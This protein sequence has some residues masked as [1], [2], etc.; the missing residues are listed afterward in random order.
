MKSSK[1]QKR[2]KSISDL[3]KNTD[4]QESNPIFGLTKNT[5]TV[6]FFDNKTD[7]EET[8]TT[9]LGKQYLDF[10]TVINKLNCKLEYVKSGSYGNVFRAINSDTNEMYCVK[11]VA[12]AKKTEYGDEQNLQ[13]PENSEICMLKLLSYF[14]LKN[15]C[16]HIIIPILTFDTKITPFLN[17]QKSGV[18]PKNNKNYKK[19]V[20]NYKKGLYSKTISVIITEWADIGDLSGFLKDN[21]KKLT[22]FQWKCLFF[23]FVVVL[24]IIQAKY[25]QFR[26]NDLKANNVLLSTATTNKISY[27]VNKKEY[28]VPSCGFTLHLWDF[29][30]ACIPGVVENIKVYQEWSNKVNITSKQNRYYDLHYFFCT[31][32]CDAFLPEILTSYNVPNEVRNFINYVVP[33]KY[34]PSK[35][36]PNVND[37]CRLLVDDEY[38]LP[39]DLLR[40][41]FFT[42][43]RKQ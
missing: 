6:N 9:F 38:I 18:V 19:F 33:S 30:F 22:L 36:N 20:E 28:L 39:C 42:E 35:D 21:Y 14:V 10:F 1:T 13:R 26:H 29:D 15:Q 11:I 8:T 7:N 41:E 25:P 4:L 31:L 2:I 27:K 12:Y 32:T 24:S 43:F 34:S 3:I 40:H 17:L 37:K 23:Q 5:D 16:P